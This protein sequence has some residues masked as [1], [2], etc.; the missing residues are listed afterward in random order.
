MIIFDI[1]ADDTSDYLIFKFYSDDGMVSSKDSDFKSFMD[2]INWPKDMNYRIDED[3]NIFLT[4]PDERLEIFIFFKDTHKDDKDRYL[5]TNPLQIVFDRMELKNNE[6]GSVYMNAV[7]AL[8]TPY[9]TK[10]KRIVS[11]V[12]R[13]PAHVYLYF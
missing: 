8:H 3:D 9:V 6:D 7:R 4:I 1:V 2:G 13:T 11:E 12:D 10:F 5:T